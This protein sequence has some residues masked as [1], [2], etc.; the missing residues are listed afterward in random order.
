MSIDYIAGKKTKAEIEILKRSEFKA[1]K[2]KP[3]KPVTDKPVKPNKNK[4]YR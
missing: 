4:S 2:K 1:Q 3:D